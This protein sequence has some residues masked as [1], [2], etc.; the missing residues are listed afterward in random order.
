MK[1]LTNGQSAGKTNHSGAHGVTR[2]TKTFRR[3][4]GDSWHNDE[5]PS[6]QA[7]RLP[8][9]ATIE[10]EKRGDSSGGAPCSALASKLLKAL[11]QLTN[12]CM[13]HPCG[14][15]T[16]DDMEWR[17]GTAFTGEEALNTALDELQEMQLIRYAGYDEDDAIGHCYAIMC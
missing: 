11:Q 6:N 15:F 8:P 16:T 17:M 14:G 13:P 2:P 10:R 7:H 5:R 3:F 4:D 1:I 9:A 12:E